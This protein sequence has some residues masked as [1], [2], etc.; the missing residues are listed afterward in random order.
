MVRFGRCVCQ[1]ETAISKL[2][3]V[4]VYL[5]LDVG[6]SRIFYFSVEQIELGTYIMENWTQQWLR[7]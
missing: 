6:I 7:S 1:L 5:S 4:G 3:F 2:L